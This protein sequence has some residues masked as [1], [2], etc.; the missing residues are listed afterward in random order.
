MKKTIL[1]TLL[2]INFSLFTNLCFAQ[3][4]GQ[5]IIDSLQQELKNYEARKIELKK[6]LYNEGDTAKVNI[7]NDLSGKFWQTGDYTRARQYADDALAISKKIAF[8]KGIA[9]AY[10]IIGIIYQDQGN[11]PDA[12]KNYFASLK[13]REEIGDKKGIAF[14]YNNIGTIYQEQGN[15]PDALKNYFA[16]LKI[17][18][19]IGNKNGI[20]ATYGNIG[21]I[22]QKQGNYPDA[23]KNYFAALKISEEIGDNYGIAFSYH[24]IGNIYGLQ[25]NYPVALKNYFASLKIREEI[26]DKYGIAGSYNNI[27]IIYNEQGN[28]P[29]ALKNHFTALKMREEIGDKKGI[30]F[31]YNNIGDLNTK[32]KN[33]KEAKKYLDDALFLSKEIESKDDIKESYSV[34]ADLDSA[35]ANWK[36]ACLHQKLYILYRDS[37]VNEESTKKILGLQLKYETE[38]KEQQIALLTKESQLQQIE[39]KKQNTSR[40]IFIGGFALFALLAGITYNRYRIKKK[41]NTEIENTLTHLKNT[42]AQ[43]IEREKLASLGK[44]TVDVARQIDVPVAHINQL[45]IKNRK[46]LS[47]IKNNKT[48]FAG[49]AV[50]E[51]KNNLLHIYQH[52]KDADG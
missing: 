40:N 37:L 21:Q 49:N 10:N 31:S 38:K 8:K 50:D 30:A 39:L 35:T 25:G 41:A 3:K 17:L 4:Q 52:G 12:L 14:S 9:N 11:Y 15:Y 48:F 33:Y 46:L 6:S 7:L 47:N 26:G 24:N 32:L 19:E 45:N 42:Q 2:T 36:D 43:L 13:M 23:L 44:L 22:Y 27:G 5:E 18:E 28:Y 20:A 34:L 16:S 29:D 51:L 1:L